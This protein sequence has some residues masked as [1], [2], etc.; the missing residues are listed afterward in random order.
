MS[1]HYCVVV[2]D[3]YDDLVEVIGPFSSW[4]AA[5]EYNDIEYDNVAAV[6]KFVPPVTR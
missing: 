6:V 4:S 2:F 3:E 1:D 5:N